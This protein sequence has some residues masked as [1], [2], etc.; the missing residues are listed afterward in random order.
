MIITKAQG[1][2]AN[3]KKVKYCAVWGDLNVCKLINM[4]EAGNHKVLYILPAPF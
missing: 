3:N 1:R 2:R 4:R